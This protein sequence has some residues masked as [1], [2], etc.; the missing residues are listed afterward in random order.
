MQKSGFLMMAHLIF[1]N[2]KIQQ[3][4]IMSSKQEM[5]LGYVPSGFNNSLFVLHLCASAWPINMFCHKTDSIILSSNKILLSFVAD[6]YGL[7]LFL[8]IDPFWVQQWWHK[9]V[10]NPFCHG[11]KGP[12]HD[13]LTSVLWRTV[14]KDVLDQVWAYK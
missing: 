2:L 9:L 8:G 11:I 5:T 3:N 6:L 7:L 12:M 10:Y 1:Q 13:L 14:K 4:K